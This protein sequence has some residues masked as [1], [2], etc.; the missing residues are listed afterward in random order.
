[1]QR[2]QYPDFGFRDE[3]NGQDRN[4]WGM[5]Y[6][7]VTVLPKYERLDNLIQKMAARKDESQPQARNLEEDG[8]ETIDLR[9]RRAQKKARINPIT[10]KAGQ[11]A[12]S[13]RMQQ[14]H[15]ALKHLLEQNTENRLKLA[16]LQQHAN[17]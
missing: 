14:V 6:S 13:A 8:F 10:G 4:L 1:M 12:S 15:L 3:L 17:Q 16:K 7:Q 9:Q 11:K 2:F 5:F